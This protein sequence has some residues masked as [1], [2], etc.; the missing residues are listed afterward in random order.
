[1]RCVEGW[2]LLL[3]SSVI[4][5]VSCFVFHFSFYSYSLAWGSDSIYDFT[6]MTVIDDR[7]TWRCT[8]FFKE[9]IEVWSSSLGK[10]HHSFF[11]P[12]RG[13]HFF[14]HWGPKRKNQ[15]S[16]LHIDTSTRTHRWKDQFPN[17]GG[18]F[19]VTVV[20]RLCVCVGS[21]VAGQIHCWFH[22]TATASSLIP[23]DML[24]GTYL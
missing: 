19:T 11:S 16:N 4:V 14:P 7:L 22:H 24:E 2:W 17:N 18:G 12:D 15:N 10:I 13:N 8:M 20:L 6:G 9:C 5:R 21:W 3:S 1:M 23:Y